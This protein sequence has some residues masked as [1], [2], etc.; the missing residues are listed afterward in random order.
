[1]EIRRC[2]ILL[3]NLEVAKK[4]ISETGLGGYSRDVEAVVRFLTENRVQ[5]AR[6]AN[7][8]LAELVP[9]AQKSRDLVMSDPARFLGVC[10]AQGE[11]DKT[12][13]LVSKANLIPPLLSLWPSRRWSKQ[14]LP[15][16]FW[17]SAPL[18][19]PPTTMRPRKV[20]WRIS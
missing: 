13:N 9:D 1:N 15:R 11:W 2:D 14:H 20:F 18:M 7:T 10:V 4:S 19:T 17:S 5:S 6:A 12:R 3:A 16:I 8:Y